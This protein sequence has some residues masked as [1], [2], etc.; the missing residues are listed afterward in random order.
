[1]TS[2]VKD[3]ACHAQVAELDEL[4][5]VKVTYNSTGADDSCEWFVTFTGSPG[6]L[7][8][9]SPL[10]YIHSRFCNNSVLP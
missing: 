10:N 9:V 2:S 8:Q 5:E 4:K 3:L 7:N 6:N 1:M